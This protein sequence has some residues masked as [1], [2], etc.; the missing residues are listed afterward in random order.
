MSEGSLTHFSSGEADR[1]ALGI[2]TSYS[3]KFSPESFRSRIRVYC[4]G[5]RVMTGRSLYPNPAHFFYDY[6][7][8]SNEYQ[9]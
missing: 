7:P 3:S 6:R 5:I 9:V 4:V 2:T 1:V 8:V